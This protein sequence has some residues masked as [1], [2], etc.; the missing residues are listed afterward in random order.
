MTRLV[1]DTSVL[2]RAVRSRQAASNRILLTFSSRRVV[3]L[4]S[5]PL[6]LEWEASICNPDDELENG[7]DR[8]QRN[9]VMAGLADLIEP[10]TLDMAW[11]PQL[12]NARDEMVLATAVRGEADA[13][14]SWNPADFSQAAAKFDIAVLS[15]QEALQR[16][17]T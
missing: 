1:L 4:A 17:W 9:D 12:R 3:L 5:I 14:I 2:A 10:V 16:W 15:P 11:R 7:L 6:F 8:A 13:I